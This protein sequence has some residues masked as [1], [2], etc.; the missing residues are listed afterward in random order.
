MKTLNQV[1]KEIRQQVDPSADYQTMGVEIEHPGGEITYIDCIHQRH[2]LECVGAEY[3]GCREIV[4]VDTDTNLEVLFIAT[5]RDG[6]EI[7]TPYAKHE[8]ENCFFS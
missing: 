2:I 3:M 8:I 5:Y 4:T 1:I 6:V 7:P